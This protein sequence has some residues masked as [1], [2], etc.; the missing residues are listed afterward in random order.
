MFYCVLSVAYVSCDSHLILLLP[1]THFC[2][3]ISSSQGKIFHIL[4]YISLQ[5]FYFHG[6]I[7]RFL[8]FDIAALGIRPSPTI[9]GLANVKNE[10]L[11]E[12]DTKNYSSVY[13]LDFRHR[14]FY[15]LVHV[16]NR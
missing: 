16:Y 2:A 15:M 4:K 8:S 9:I 12:I 1:Y 13:V 14:R 11:L 3:C 5:T 6:H 10:L 7:S